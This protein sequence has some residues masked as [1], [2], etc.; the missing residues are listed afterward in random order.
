MK[1]LTLNIRQGGGS[2]AGRLLDW[3]GET[4]P[5]VAVLTEFRRGGSGEKLRK[6]LQAHGLRHFAAPESPERANSVLIASRFPL[7]AREAE[8]SP[9]D[10]HRLA[11]VS[12]EGIE[13]LGVY[14]AQRN[15][16]ASL[17]RTLDSLS[18]KLLER[19]SLIL[20]DFNTG[21]RGIDEAGK[22]FYAEDCFRE[23]LE[24]GWQD[25][26]RSRHPET[27]EYSWYSQREGGFRIDHALASPELD[28]RIVSATYEHSVR[29][30]EISDHSALV[31]EVGASH[32][33]GKDHSDV[34]RS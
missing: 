6:G 27:T 2:R 34:S 18:G 22:T 9:A 25:A 3:L 30:A 33:R 24:R 20:G 28:E 10:A 19:Q 17:Y 7:L 15:E 26:W 16:K 21:I 4:A 32:G 29:E 1:L 14:F 13:L 12:V 5:D 8:T 31:I 11:W 23:L